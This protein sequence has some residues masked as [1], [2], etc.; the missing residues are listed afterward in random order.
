MKPHET[1]KR[2]VT[3]IFDRC[4]EK[5]NP[6]CDKYGLDTLQKFQVF[7]LSRRTPDTLRLGRQLCLK[8]EVAA[9]QG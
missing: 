8:M 6:P 5:C 9:A 7:E 1:S 2:M 4:N 3:H